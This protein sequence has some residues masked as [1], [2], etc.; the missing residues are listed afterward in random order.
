V[1]LQNDKP[2]MFREDNESPEPFEKCKPSKRITN[3]ATADKV[4]FDKEMTYLQGFP[5]IKKKDIN[6][7]IIES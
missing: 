6:G 5:N 2:K 1:N 7:C 4:L 3:I